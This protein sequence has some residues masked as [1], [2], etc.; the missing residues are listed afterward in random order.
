MALDEH[1]LMLKANIRSFMEKLEV[2]P[3]ETEKQNSVKHE[4]TENHNKVQLLGEQKQGV[5]SQDGS[6]R[7]NKAGFLS[8]SSPLAYPSSYS[9]SDGRPRGDEAVADI[10]VSVTQRPV[11]VTEVQPPDVT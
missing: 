2:A 5:V 8:Q 4:N 10:S 3:A 6:G 11:E 1:T 9:K 7:R